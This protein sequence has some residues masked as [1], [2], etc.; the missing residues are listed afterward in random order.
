[1]S[2]QELNELFRPLKDIHA[3]RVSIDKRTGHPRGF[4]H[5]DFF[6]EAAATAAMAQLQGRDC[7]GRILRIDYGVPAAQKRTSRKD[8]RVVKAAGGKSQDV[9]SSVSQRSGEQ[10]EGTSQAAE[11]T[12]DVTSSS[13]QSHEE[14]SEGTSQPA[15]NISDH[16]ETGKEKEF[17][18]PGQGPEEQLHEETDKT[19]ED[20]A[21]Q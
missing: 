3:V 10:A 7:K 20:Q 9:N 14:H 17:E 2:D 4:A 11:K 19:P 18:Q 15:E 6:S 21:K 13:E 5:A 8:E 1:M 12:K 16:P